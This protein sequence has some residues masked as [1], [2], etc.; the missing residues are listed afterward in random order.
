[1]PPTHNILLLDEDEQSALNIQRFLKASSY[2][3]NLNHASDIQEGAN[4]LKNHKPDLILL[5]SGM[6]NKRDFNQF[7]ESAHHDGIPIILLADNGTAETRQQAEMAGANDYLVKNKINLF[8]LQKAILNTLKINETEARIDSTVNQ[9]NARHDALYKMLDKIGSA[10]LIIN[11]SNAMVYS[12][13]G[14]Y[15]LLSDDH[16]REHIANYL[17]YREL[18]ED[19]RIELRPNRQTSLNL[20]ISSIEWDNT[21]ANLVLIDKGAI[22]EEKPEG[23]LANETLLTL[24]NSVKG[25][26]LL[27][28]DKQ[29]HFI[30][31]PA[32]KILNAKLA[33]ILRQPMNAY[34]EV[35]DSMPGE[36]SVRTFLNERETEG[37]IKLPGGSSQRAKF[38]IKPVSIA[39][40]LY[41]L[42]S[43]EL[44]REQPEKTMP[45]PGSEAEHFSNEAVLQLASHD[46]REPVRTI[47]NYVQLIS[48]NLEKK[49]YEAASEYADFAR[50]TAGRMEKLLTDL[51]VYIGLNDYK[52]TLSKVQLKPIIIEALRPL[53]KKI[54]ETGAEI[55][56]ADLPDVNADRELMQRLIFQLVDNAIKFRKKNKRLTVDIGFDKFDGNI[57]FCIRDNGIGISR[58]YYQLIFDAFERLNRVDEYPGNGLGLAIC[59]KIVEMHGGEIWV[60]SL[61]GSGSNFYFTLRSS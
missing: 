25:N 47:L 3:F 9:F 54:D 1:M 40:E 31:K 51:K 53:K 13:A 32:L 49:R 28:R 4:Y 36:L 21:K 18:E 30:N 43:F 7:R 27:V 44:I 10:V 19:E 34:M 58:K 22:K 11:S 2:P 52:F 5:D 39:D 42:I 50:D 15:N 14:A 23:T 26:V 55:N 41:E 35:N 46:L 6:V 37:A 48:E 45:K 57:I 20:R 38:F 12:N 17:T 59:K 29:V 60:E 8:H 24:L 16:L 56:V 33:D 61:P